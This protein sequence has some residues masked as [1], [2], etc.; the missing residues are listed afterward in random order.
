MAFFTSMF[1]QQDQQ[2]RGPTGQTPY[3][4]P[5]SNIRPPGNTVNINGGND[6]NRGDAFAAFSRLYSPLLQNNAQMIQQMG[7]Q[8]ITGQPVDTRLGSAQMQPQQP[9][10]FGPEDINNALMSMFQRQEDIGTVSKFGGF[11]PA[12]RRQPYWG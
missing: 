10:R 8:P 6:A 3:N 5:A 9:Q 1:P 11:S 2:R 12:T 7:A 4:V